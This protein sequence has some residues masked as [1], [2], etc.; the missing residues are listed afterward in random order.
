[1]QMYKEV[2]VISYIHYISIYTTQLLKKE[3]LKGH[4]H[5]K[6]FKAYTFKW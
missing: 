2:A 3:E 1:M 4:S 6:S 5:E